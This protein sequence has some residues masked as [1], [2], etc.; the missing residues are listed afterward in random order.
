[1]TSTRVSGYCQER[2]GSRAASEPFE[3]GIPSQC[4]WNAPPRPFL[5]NVRGGDRRGGVRKRR[6]PRSFSPGESGNLA[7]SGV[8]YNACRQQLC[9]PPGGTGRRGYRFGLLAPTAAGGN[10]S[11]RRQCRRGR[12]A[13]SAAASAGRGAGGASQRVAALVSETCC[14]ANAQ[15]SIRRHGPRRHRTAAAV[16][17][18]AALDPPTS[19]ARQIG[20]GAGDGAPPRQLQKRWGWSA[21]GARRSNRPRTASHARPKLSRQAFFETN[22]RSTARCHDGA[23]TTGPR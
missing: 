17:S 22:T 20:K 18:E 19:R 10:S 21:T 14:C 6:P 2:I 12:E 11:G 5:Q 3:R 15:Q 7:T 16:A 8:F 1:M 13:G 23:M 4:G 9:V